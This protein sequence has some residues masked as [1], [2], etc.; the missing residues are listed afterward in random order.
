MPETTTE[1]FWTTALHDYD[2]ARAAAK[3]ALDGAD[4]PLP[5]EYDDGSLTAIKRNLFE[6]ELPMDSLTNDDFANG[7]ALV[8]KMFLEYGDQFACCEVH[9]E[10][11][12]AVTRMFASAVAR[13][14]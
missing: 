2:Q 8:L 13:S 11:L 7:C 3:Q 14:R 1:A 10:H 5:P 4:V 9:G 12:L 6:L